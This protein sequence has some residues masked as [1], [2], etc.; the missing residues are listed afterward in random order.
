MTKLHYDTQNDLLIHMGDIV[1]KGPFSNDLLTRFAEANVTGVRG[2]N[3]QKV[4]GECEVGSRV[5]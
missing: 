4:I 2:N 3:D 5:V 1:A